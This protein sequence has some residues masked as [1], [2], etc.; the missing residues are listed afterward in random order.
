VAERPTA[1]MPASNK[2]GSGNDALDDRDGQGKG[3]SD[4]RLAPRWTRTTLD[5]ATSYA[6]QRGPTSLRRVSSTT[7]TPSTSGP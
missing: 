7:S 3:E 6:E 2:R 5:T 4:G 1:P